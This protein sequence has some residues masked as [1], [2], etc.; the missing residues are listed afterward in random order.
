[1]RLALRVLLT[2]GIGA[3]TFAVVW[4]GLDKAAQWAALTAVVLAA[5]AWLLPVGKPDEV[6][7]EMDSQ[8]LSFIKAAGGIKQ[9][10]EGGG[11]LRRRQRVKGAWVRGDVIQ[12]DK[13]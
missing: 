3:I 7:Q 4:A 2:I 10:G 13:K 9:S 6:N 11:N 8:E 1:M 12:E 5:A